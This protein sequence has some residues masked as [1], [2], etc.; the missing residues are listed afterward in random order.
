[1]YYNYGN[2]F[3]YQ[4]QFLRQLDLKLYYYKFRKIKVIQVGF[5]LSNASGFLDYFQ[6]SSNINTRLEVTKNL[7]FDFNYQFRYRKLDDSSYNNR[8]FFIKASYNF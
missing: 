8:Y 5:N 3:Y 7:F 2:D 4:E 6:I 1:M